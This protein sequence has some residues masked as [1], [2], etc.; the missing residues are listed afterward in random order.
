MFEYES[1][2]VKE[3]A[4]KELIET[5]AF[6]EAWEKVTFPVKKDGTP[7]AIKSKNIA[8]ASITTE[9]YHTK[10]IEDDLTVYTGY[11]PQIGYKHDSISLYFSVNNPSPKEKE[12]IEAK[13]QNV[14]KRGTWSYDAY[15]YDIEDIKNAVK[16]HIEYLKTRKA[17]IKKDL[18][19]ISKDCE[20]FGK[21]F[22]KAKSDLRISN[23]FAYQILEQFHTY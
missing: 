12:L 7:F 23:M 15:V 1:R 4:E 6:I 13:P 5:T 16:S 8:N 14:V 11:Y 22:A 18:P 19:K 10:G 3:I 20:N 2:K 17:M 21:A 9:S